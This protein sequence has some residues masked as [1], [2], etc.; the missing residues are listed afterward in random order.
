[1]QQKSVGQPLTRVEGRTKVTGK[2]LYTAD[3]P[4]PNCA[5]AV[6][7]MSSIAK[8]RIVSIDTQNAV[9]LPGVLAIMTHENTPKLPKPKN[10]EPSQSPPRII[11]LLQDDRVLYANQPIAIAIAETLE[12]AQ[13]AAR[14]VTPRYAPLAPSVQLEP[15]LA[16]VYTPKTAGNGEST[17]SAR[18]DFAAGMEQAEVK[19]EHVYH[20]PFETHNP[21]EPHATTA[22]WD[23]ED[24]LTLYDATQGLF[25]DRERV[26]TLLGL[27]PDN[28]RVISLVLGG[29]F[30]S[31]GPTW[32]HVVLTAMA[33][34][35]VKRPVKLEV[36][37]P[38]MFGAV[39]QRSRTRQSIA[40]GAK[41]DGTITA[42]RHDV[43]SQTSTF[44]EFV[45]SSSLAS[46]MLYASPNAETSQRLV[47]SDIGTPSFMRAPGEST[48]TYGLEC[49]MDELAVAL[50][51]D[52]VELR[53]K[54]Y[55]DTDPEKNLP[56]SSKSLRECYKMGGD[57]FGWS[58]RTPAPRS[59]RDGK[60]LIG[61]GM[62]SSVYPTR[63]QES[64]ALARIHA[65]GSIFV[66]SGTQDL[67]TGTYT[68]MTQI[69][70]D[71]IGV[72]PKEVTFRLGDTEYPETP[73]SGGS[74]TAASTGSAVHLAGQTLREKVVQLAVSDAQS[75]AYNANSNDV[76]ISGGRISV[77]GASRSE[78]VQALLARHKLEQLE[79]EATATPGAEKNEYSMYAF[80]AQFAEVRVDEDLGM[81][82]VSRMVGCFGAGKIL[83]PKTARSQFMGGMIWGIG[84][85]LL[86][87]NNYDVRL[88]RIV[89]NNLSEYLVP[90]NADVPAI[91]AM[92]VDEVD[93]HVNPLGVKGIGEI[94]IT[95]AA[96]AIAN[97]VYHAT[98]K[99]VRDL[100]ITLDK[101]L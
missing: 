78:T 18:G 72:D 36:A 98:G 94:G 31:K 74:Q 87:E 51:M 2:A 80:G 83:N 57:K 44:D 92:W 27:E 81:L 41:R 35:Q 97:A 82:R 62:A 45:E 90:V 91:E 52:P 22:V 3:Q 55:A 101:L 69:A 60:T 6:L 43:V 4:V 70:A 68:I 85:A 71:A 79:A 49:G 23:G 9:K 10:A 15:N 88:G 95:G 76:V 48:G 11:Q 64:H 53:I 21:M 26:A 47:R 86:E 7:V 17:D 8:G 75:P 38:Q 50:N 24:K 63:R 99:R 40:I 25:V 61:W 34:R 84:L 96:A 56:W 1:M 42:L 66:E 89:N 65:D 93:T 58:K 59:M 28:V 73:V 67:G 5:Y 100:P 16:R 54:N 39:G 37:R 77:R 30:G 20:T 32:S 19:I 46:R 14:L 12:T 29:G 33:A 13:E